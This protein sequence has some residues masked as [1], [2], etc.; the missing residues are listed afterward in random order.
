M[1]NYI[2]TSAHINSANSIISMNF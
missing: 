2:F 1:E